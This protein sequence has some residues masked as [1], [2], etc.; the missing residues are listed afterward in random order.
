M[1]VGVNVFQRVW[2]HTYMRLL[3]FISTAITAM[4]IGAAIFSRMAPVPF[5]IFIHR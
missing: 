4:T 3:L 2:D 1:A 5:P